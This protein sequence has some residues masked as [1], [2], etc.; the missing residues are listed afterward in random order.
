MTIEKT[1]VLQKLGALPN[2]TMADVDQCLKAAL[3]L[4]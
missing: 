3:Q 4:S 1:L 2:K